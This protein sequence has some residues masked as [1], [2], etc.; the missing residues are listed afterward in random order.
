[1]LIQHANPVGIDRAI[2]QV[3]TRLHAQ[4]LAKWN[5]QGAP[6]SYQCHERCYRNRT[7]NGYRA[8]IYEAG[9]EYRDVYWDDRLA[10]IS[11]FG[12]SDDIVTGTQSS[13]DVHLVFFVNLAKLK[14][15]LSH[16]ADEEVRADVESILAAG[17]FGFEM[18]DTELW[19]ENVLREYPATLIGQDGLAN[20]N[21]KY[22]DIHPVHCFRINLQS[23]YDSGSNC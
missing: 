23:F 3:Q 21:L 8:E 1:M 11:F 12:I 16:R 6:E 17:L 14:P 22:V 5:L 20:E 2:Q 19:L 10:A 4:L 13:T 18:V 15:A 7:A 9:N